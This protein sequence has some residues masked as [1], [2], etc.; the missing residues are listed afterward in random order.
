[1]KVFFLF[2]VTFGALV[3]RINVKC[4]VPVASFGG[5]FRSTFGMTNMKRNQI[6]QQ[7]LGVPGRISTAPISWLGPLI[8]LGSTGRL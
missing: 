6:D 3:V 8:M 5:C 1:M 4:S 2:F 7:R